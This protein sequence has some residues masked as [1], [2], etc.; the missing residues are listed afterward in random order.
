MEMLFHLENSW[1]LLILHGQ[2]GHANP[3]VFWS[4]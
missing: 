1:S 3:S 4:R 2:G